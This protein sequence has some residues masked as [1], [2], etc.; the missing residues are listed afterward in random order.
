MNGKLKSNMTQFILRSKCGYVDRA[1][2]ESRQKKKT[3]EIDEDTLEAILEVTG[4]LLET[5]LNDKH[6]KALLREV[7][8]MTMEQM[9]EA[10][11]HVQKGV[12]FGPDSPYIRVSETENIYL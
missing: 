2:A 10:G 12:I 5:F 1:P 11:Y 9:N 8:G 6:G 7:A 4:P 3:D